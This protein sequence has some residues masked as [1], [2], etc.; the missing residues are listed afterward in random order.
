MTARRASLHLWR[1]VCVPR[2]VFGAGV[3][4]RSRDALV[5]V[6]TIRV[7]D[8]L[9][10]VAHDQAGLV[11][12]R[13][14]DDLGVRADTRTILVRR[15]TWRRVARGVYDVGLHLDESWEGRHERSIWEAVLAG[16]PDAVPV[17]LTALAVHGVWGL[18]RQLPAMA[19]L[20]AGRRSR[21][22]GPVVRRQF[23]RPHETVVVRGIEVVSLPVALV[24][25][26]PEVGRDLAVVILDNCLNRELITEADL[27]EIQRGVRGRRGAARLHDVWPLVDGRA[28]SPLETRARLA[29][30]D[31]GLPPDDLQL[32]VTDDADRFL[33]RG[34]LAWR[35]RRDGAWIVVEMD[36]LDIHS[37][38]RPLFTDRSRQN[39]LARHSSVTLLR[40]TGEDVRNGT[41]VREL[42][43]ETAS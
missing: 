17:G 12:A 38:P 34:D 36:G 26:L 41:L 28:A 6:R 5:R 31:A 39:R 1:R 23:A 8:V 33:A 16:P 15:R 21:D 10:D 37:A 7:P 11:S 19:A 22:L 43:A 24:Q 20:G 4:R 3:A 13:Q 42:R 29:C 2:W 35:R 27:H 32:V 25:A 18:P 30:I 9:L 40:Y 14:S